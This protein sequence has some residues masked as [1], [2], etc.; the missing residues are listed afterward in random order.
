MFGKLRLEFAFDLVGFVKDFLGPTDASTALV[1]PPL[2]YLYA[3]REFLGE[4]VEKVLFP[5]ADDLAERV[6]AGVFAEWAEF[7]FEFA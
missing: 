5:L 2:V 3:C 1:K 7:V 6:E 4:A